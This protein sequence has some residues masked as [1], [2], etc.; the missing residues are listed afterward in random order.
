MNLLET[1]VNAQNGD[2]LRRI[3]DQFQLDEGQ[4]RSAVDALVPAL[5]RGISNNAS[6]P[7]GLESL[8]G[9][10]ACGNHGKYLDKPEAST[11]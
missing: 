5:S 4:T 11:T 10:L 7:E 9:A 2:V 3:S 6:S 8:I 1:L